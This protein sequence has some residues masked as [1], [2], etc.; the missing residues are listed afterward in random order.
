MFDLNGNGKTPEKSVTGITN[1][2]QEYRAHLNVV[3]E[4]LFQ[5][6]E[7]ALGLKRNE[8][9]DC[10]KGALFG[11]ING[12]TRAHIS[13]LFYGKKDKQSFSQH[14]D[15]LIMEEH[16]DFTTVTLIT[17]SAPGI[18]VKGEVS[19]EQNKVSFKSN[20]ITDNFLRIFLPK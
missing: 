9:V 16:T 3:A 18:E 1:A 14:D 13:S 19:V 5:R 8:L 2:F 10:H 12:E 6:F 11:D 17:A 20:K 4:F 7:T 15:D